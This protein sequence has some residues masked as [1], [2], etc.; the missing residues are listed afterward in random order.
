MPDPLFTSPRGKLTDIE[1]VG[2][3]L[4]R[5]FRNKALVNLYERVDGDIE[6][7]VLTY[8]YSNGNFKRERAIDIAES[9]DKSK[10]TVTDALIRLH[11]KDVT[12]RE[13][14]KA[15]KGRPRVYWKLK[16]PTSTSYC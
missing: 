3:R 8:L 16:I 5:F 1:G 2:D 15:G 7:A 11:V 4:Q 9:L 6:E 13:V 10:N 14:E 12:E